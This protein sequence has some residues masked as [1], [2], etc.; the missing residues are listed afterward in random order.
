MTDNT[1]AALQEPLN[2]AVTNVY[3][4]RNKGDAAIVLALVSEIKRIFTN[5]NITIFS[6]DTKNDSGKYNAPVSS[7]LMW[8]L[9]SSHKHES[10]INQIFGLFTRLSGL[11]VFLIF[12]KFGIRNQYWL[13]RRDLKDHVKNLSRNDIVIACGG[14][15]LGNADTSPRTLLLLSG[16]CL[17]F[18]IGHYIGKPVYMYS[19]SIGP[20][21]GRLAKKMVAFS[22]N[23]VNLIEI[24][25]DVS[26]EYI[27]SLGVNTPKIMTA[28]PVFLLHGRQAPSPIKLKKAPLQVGI[29]VRK[30]FTEPAEF[31]N[32]LGIMAKLIDY[33]ADVHSAQ[34]TYIPQV[35]AEDFNDDDRKVASKLHNLVKNKDNFTVLSKDYHPFE[36]MGICGSMDI[37]VG[38]RMHSN[39]FSL[40]GETPVVA[41]MYEH[42]TQG[43]MNGLGLG[44]M[45]LNI[46][47]LTYK[48]LKT[49]V[50]LA[51]E[52]KDHFKDIIRLNMPQQKRLSSSAMNEIRKVH[53]KKVEEQYATI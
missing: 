5:G 39:I 18:L 26:F 48:E 50:D 30:W 11:V 33:L 42:K 25:E 15:Y 13:L 36:L 6:T 38:T 43:I 47:D 4:Y 23:R 45:T 2:I 16:M 19:Q 9:F 37:F 27:K 28:D 41:I 32:Y 53:K 46:G 7:S 49:K 22:L 24:R 21:K 52:Q 20:L 17:S 34:I 51:I 10:K 35:I 31:N 14:G 12:C 29:T 3:S 44:D 8:V 1:D 40:L